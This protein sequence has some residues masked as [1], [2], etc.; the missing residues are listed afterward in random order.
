M[1][2][3]LSRAAPYELKYFKYS[4]HYWILKFLAASNRPLRILNVGTAQGYLGAILGNLGHCIVGVEKIQPC[5]E[6]RHAFIRVFT[7]PIL[8]LSIFRLKRNLT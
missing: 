6:G 8:K 5:R 3:H 7:L 4:S 1:K 2:T